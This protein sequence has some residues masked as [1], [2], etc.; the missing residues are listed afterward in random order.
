MPF[1]KAGESPPPSASREHPPSEIPSVPEKLNLAR[2]SLIPIVRLDV[3]VVSDV[4]AAGLAAALV[5]HVL[6]L[7]SQVP[8]PVMQLARMAGKN[9]DKQEMNKKGGKVSRAVKNRTELL[10]SFDTLAS[11][12]TTTFTALS[13]A[14]AKAVDCG[15]V[16]DEG[17]EDEEGRR[18]QKAQKAR[19]YLAILVGPSLG[20]A[21]A[22]VLFA[23]DGLEVTVWGERE[24]G[25]AEEAVGEDEEGVESQEEDEEEDAESEGEEEGKSEEEQV[26]E[27]DGAGESDDEA[28]PPPSS[29]SPSPSPSHPP[30]SPP[31]PAPQQKSYMTH[32]QQ[33]QTLFSAERL[34]SRTLADA[35]AHG[36]GLNSDMA[37][38]QT[39]LLIRAP[40]RFSHPAWVPRQNVTSMMESVLEE[41]LEESGV[42]RGK[43]GRRG[44]KKRVEG[45]WVVC[46]EAGRSEVDEPVNEDDEMIWW[47]WEGKLVGFSDW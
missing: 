39:H 11:H 16:V 36:Y 6:F 21:K 43:D 25:A 41:F 13:T 20:T 38:T 18:R 37:P 45:V 14:F 3:D 44:N 2:E 1:M 4:L 26:E 29:P 15:S 19:A 27:V 35:D 17:V 30:L 7:K 46:R 42:R 28:T 22:K 31:L 47:N 9:G 34:L 10:A 40:R 24:D 5:G 23:V 32:G 12:L 8:L 33:Q